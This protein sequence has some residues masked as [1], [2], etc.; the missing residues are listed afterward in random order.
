MSLTA[1]EIKDGVE[2]LSHWI[3]RIEAT[4]SQHRDD[5]CLTAEQITSVAADGQTLTATLTS[6]LD[7]VERAAAD[8]RFTE[9]PM[10]HL[11]SEVTRLRDQWFLLCC[12]HGF[13]PQ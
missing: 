12:S 7:Q 13:D 10:T 2:G 4:L 11:L 1:D 5:A 6:V 8:P 3:A 9:Y